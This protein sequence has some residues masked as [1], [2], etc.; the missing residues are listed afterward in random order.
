VVTVE[1]SMFEG[2]FVRAL[3][4][5]RASAFAEELR[6][7][8]YD[9]DAPKEHYDVAVWTACLDVAGARLHPDASREE[10]WRRLGRTFAKGYFDTL[11]GRAIAAV[12]PWMRAERFLE[13]G[14]Q[15]LRTGLGGAGCDVDLMGPGEALVLLHGPHPG[16]AFVLTGV[17]EECFARMGVEGTFT[18]TVVEGVEGRIAVRWRV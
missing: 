12:L 16:S 15:F 14:P 13:R 11:I 6:R 1:A 7:A 3:R 4:V 2:L 17:L 10:A 5:E 9:L 8:G 18:P